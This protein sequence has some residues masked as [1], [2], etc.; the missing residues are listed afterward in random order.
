MGLDLSSHIYCTFYRHISVAF[1]PLQSEEPMTAD[2]SKL[3][4]ETPAA[5]VVTTCDEK[6]VYW[7]GRGEALFG[8]S[9]AEAVGRFLSEI[10]V[11][12]DQ[13]E[14]GRAFL[15]K[16]LETGVNTFEC[17]RQRKN[18]FLVYVYISSKVLSNAQGE[19]E[20][21]LSSVKDLT[22]IRLLSDATLIEPGFR[23]LIEQ[24][25]ADELLQQSEDRFSLLADGA[26]DY[27][28][29][30]LNP[31]GQVM[32]WNVGAE[33]ING[34]KAQEIIG[35]HFS[36]FYPA[37]AV[38]QGKPQW[39]LRTALEQGHI[40]DQDWRI[41]KNGQQFWA[42]D[43]ITALFDKDGSLR[44]FGK[45]TR[46]MTEQ[47]MLYDKNL[48]LQIRSDAKD[49]FLASMSHELRT[50]LNG[51]I[52]FAEFLVDGK[53]GA[54][55]PKQKEYL[56]EILTSGRRLFQVVNDVLNLNEVG[57]NRMELRLERFSLHKAIEEVNAVAK[58][59]AE[60]KKIHL[61]VDVAPELGD[62]IIDRQKFKEILYNL[63]SNAIKFTHDG[64]KVEIRAAP[65]GAHRFKVA[66]KDTGIGIKP[67]DF[68][69]IFMA[70][71]QL[72]SGPSRPYEGSGL[73]LTSARKIVELQGGTI[74]VESEV[75]KGSCF[76]FVLPL[77]TPEVKV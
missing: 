65:L 1:V 51:I 8:Y 46:D 74:D 25:Q 4:D 7:N 57:A 17:I 40:E 75:G 35:E 72:E 48:E 5:I 20:F 23:D 15:R 43:V 53:S 27:A 19:I 14:M 13:V 41:R 11:P 55:N 44:G 71:E 31:L 33:R 61:A 36:C 50:P 12:P 34:Y 29:F 70:F 38:A 63:L 21:V 59:D 58:P 67:E 9:S 24:R 64:G 45:V 66:V 22:K 30:L 68:Q 49:R 28:S 47:K 73:G 16:T 54:I 3:L 39:E 6:V 10:I 56:E 18:G 52:G 32:S 76:T 69:R 62:V 77:V 26:Q 60:K 37:D 42:T 2:I